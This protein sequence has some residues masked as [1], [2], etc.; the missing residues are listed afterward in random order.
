MTWFIP[1]FH[2]FAKSVSSLCPNP[3]VADYSV[4]NFYGWVAEVWVF[5]PDALS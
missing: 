3:F 4:G 5:C 2:L 1:I